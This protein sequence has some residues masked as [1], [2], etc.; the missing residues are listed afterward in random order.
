MWGAED[1]PTIFTAH[2]IEHM[3]RE[4]LRSRAEELAPQVVQVLTGEG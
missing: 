4:A 2:P 1:Y 3:T